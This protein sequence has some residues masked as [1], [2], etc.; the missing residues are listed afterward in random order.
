MQAP[1]A[2]S[3]RQGLCLRIQDAKVSNRPW[4]SYAR[5]YLPPWLML[6]CSPGCSSC[7]PGTPKPEVSSSPFIKLLLPMA[8]PWPD[9]RR[10]A[11]TWGSIRSALETGKG[12]TQGHRD[13][14]GDY[15]RRGHRG[16]ALLARKDGHCWALTGDQTQNLGVC[17]WSSLLGWLRPGGACITFT[18]LPGPLLPSHRH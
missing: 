9:P 18:C 1:W 7:R 12:F 2:F 8:R 13:S 6:L 15:L 3:G 10:M 17:T 11:S 4:L 5:S 14:P 16:P